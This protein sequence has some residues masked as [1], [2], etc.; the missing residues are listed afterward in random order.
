[1][2]T[3]RI[4]SWLCVALW[5]LWLLSLTLTP[6]D[7][8]QAIQL[9]PFTDSTW[10]ISCLLSDCAWTSQALAIVVI[11]ILGNVAVFVPLG[12]ALTAALALGRQEKGR[13]TKWSTWLWP[14][15][16]GFSFSVCIELAQLY[17]PGRVTA[18]DDVILNTLG[19]ALGAWL[20]CALHPWLANLA[21]GTRRPR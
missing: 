7:R 4:V 19:T 10:A 21:Q 11:Q 6:G 13:W 20:T 1:M 18:T 8:P 9:V 12:A 3:A 2:K 5:A 17:V 15:A 16:L 14:I